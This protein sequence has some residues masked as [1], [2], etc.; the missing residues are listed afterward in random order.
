M[1]GV[2]KAFNYPG[3]DWI[4]LSGG[5]K[6]GSMFVDLGQDCFLIQ[7]VPQPT[8]K[9]TLL[10]LWLSTE[11]GMIE[12]LTSLSEVGEKRRS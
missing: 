12:C 4:T 6:V 11:K 9:E 7:Y 5:N 10:K 2:M 3:L 8:R 1:V